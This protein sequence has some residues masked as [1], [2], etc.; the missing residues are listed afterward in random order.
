MSQLTPRRSLGLLLGLQSD[1]RSRVGGHDWPVV[2]AI[3]LCYVVFGAS[4][5]LAQNAPAT[6]A[7]EVK[8]A[9]PKDV[10]LETKDGVQIRATWFAGVGNRDTVPVMMVH[11]FK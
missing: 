9:P 11:G 8:V 4:S 7:P 2:L 10:D 6:P 1:R 5:S 3:S